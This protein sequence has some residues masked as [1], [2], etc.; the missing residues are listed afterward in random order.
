MAFDGIII[1]SLV[2]DFTDSI[3]GGKIDK[4]YQP[5][6]DEIVLLIRGKNLEGKGENFRLL[7]SANA[8]YPRV[9]FINNYKENPMEAPMF[10]M[11]LRKHLGGGK[12]ISIEQPEFERILHFNILTRNE[13]GDSITKTLIIE[14]MGK[15]SN[16]ILTEN[17]IILDSIK[18][19]SYDR[20]KVRQI[21][22][23]KNYT[24]PPTQNK[25]NPLKTF[26]DTDIKNNNNYEK[27]LYE[28]FS[29]I[30]P[31]SSSLLSQMTTEKDI[32]GLHN[33]FL[34]VIAS[35][36]KRDFMPYIILSELH[37]P[38][39]FCIFGSSVYDNANILTFSNISQMLEY[40]YK[41]KDDSSRI[42]NRSTD[43]KRLLQNNIERCIK[44]ADIQKKSLNEIKNR[45]TFKLYGEL[46][47]ANAYAISQGDEIC[48]LQNFY[49]QD[50][51]E[52]TINLDKNKTPTENAQAYFK[53]YKKQKRTYLALLEQIAQNKEELSYLEGVLVS[54]A[55]CKDDSDLDQIREELFET[56]II[57]KRAIVKK[58][59]KAI[60]KQAKPLHY[61]SSDGFDIY[62]GKNNK[63][64]DE[65]TL[66]TANNDDIWLHT[67]LIPGSHVI[68]KVKNGETSE[69]ALTE[70]AHLAAFYSKARESSLVPVDYCKRKYV[71]KPNAAK[72]GMVIYDNNKTAYITPNE[73][74][75]NL[76]KMQGEV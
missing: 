13:L 60:K 19:V 70:A 41:N 36:E 22:P 32:N 58:R 51:P 53:K 37:T 33:A 63:Q 38:K 30:S 48:I 6:K 2:N 57:K 40:F 28:N 24:S 45:D 61:V 11:F 75:I 69:V 50:L 16:I 25:Q 35:L 29:G 73:K 66:R 20:S 7:L 3:L 67:K 71:R 12:I 74:L 42:I 9:H 39:E 5:E 76:L 68:L 15:H 47:T 8:S 72:A 49:E 27:V 14:V 43:L 59:A 52:I 31:F 64:N 17:N 1:H 62:V 55:N 54:L 46:I 44:K 18:H 21:L 34:T 56:G 65:L 10:C 26:Y 23:G 4:I